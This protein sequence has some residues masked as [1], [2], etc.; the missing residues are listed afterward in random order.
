M[1]NICLPLDP[2]ATRLLFLIGLFSCTS[3]ESNTILGGAGDSCSATAACQPGFTCQAERCRKLCRRTDKCGSGQRCT[4]VGGGTLCMPITERICGDSF[5]DVPEICDDGDDNSNTRADACRLDCQPARCSDGVEDSGEECDDGALNSNTVANACRGNCVDAFCGDGVIDSGEECDNRDNNSDD[6][7]DACRRNCDASSC[8]DGVVDTG[9]Q[10][11]DS[12]EDSSD[13][14]YQ[15]AFT[16]VELTN[17]APTTLQVSHHRDSGA[18]TMVYTQGSVNGDR[19]L[20][21][22]LPLAGSAASAPTPVSDISLLT[23]V[24]SEFGFISSSQEG[25]QVAVAFTHEF[26]GGVVEG[27]VPWKV[28]RS[29]ISTSGDAGLTWSQDV[30]QMDNL[31]RATTVPDTG[32][33]GA[34]PISSF[35][36]VNDS[37]FSAVGF[38]DGN[39]AL[40]THQRRS[41]S[42]TEACTVKPASTGRDHSSLST[43]LGTG[44]SPERQTIA[45]AFLLTGYTWASRANGKSVVGFYPG[46]TSASALQSVDGGRTWVVHRTFNFPF[47]IFN[48]YST[49]SFVSPKPGSLVLMDRR[50]IDISLYAYG[51]IGTDWTDVTSVPAGAT[52]IKR[53]MVSDGASALTSIWSEYKVGEAKLLS[54]T[55]VNGGETFGGVNSLLTMTGSDYLGLIQATMSAGNEITALVCSGQDFK[56]VSRGVGIFNFHSLGHSVPCLGDSRLA[57]LRWIDGETPALDSL[58]Y[59][60]DATALQ[61]ARLVRDNAGRHTALWTDTRPTSAGLFALKL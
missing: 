23:P 55:S 25:G 54:A 21:Q 11:D 19:L 34:C 30:Q 14:C 51:N 6:A 48:Y 45:G 49:H 36:G 58:E 27:V 1:H 50:G 37:A 22:T 57:V 33:A 2:R 15:C 18:I 41:Y 28:Q 10:C 43:D 60:T 13:G 24:G 32:A 59:L 29:F 12:N 9:E 3:T 56:P 44:L 46:T 31:P 5:V 53:V 4:E 61:E 42:T 47:N 26:S 17:R 40:L 38:I 20:A 35:T 52:V 7:R 39:L 8:G 16:V